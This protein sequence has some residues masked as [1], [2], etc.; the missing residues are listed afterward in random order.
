[1]WV[2]RIKKLLGLCLNQVFSP[3]HPPVSVK[4]K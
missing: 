2:Y 4:L 1:L 3:H